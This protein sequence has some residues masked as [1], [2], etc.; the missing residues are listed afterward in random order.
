MVKK[1]SYDNAFKAKVALEALRGDQTIAKIA[2]HYNVAS[3][4]VSK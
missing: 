4:L 1:T 3:S 2:A